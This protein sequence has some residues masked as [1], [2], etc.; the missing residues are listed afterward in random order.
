[1]AKREKGALMATSIYKHEERKAPP[2]TRKRDGGLTLM[3]VT[4]PRAMVQGTG[5]LHVQRKRKKGEIFYLE[6]AANSGS[7]AA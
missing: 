4:A 6:K 5:R 7:K 1:M 3:E 2:S